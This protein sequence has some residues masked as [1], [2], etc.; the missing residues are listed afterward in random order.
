MFSLTFLGLLNP[1]DSELEAVHCQQEVVLTSMPQ[2][3]DIRIPRDEIRMIAI[4][5]DQ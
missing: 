2:S 4:S 3:L 1:H 5:N